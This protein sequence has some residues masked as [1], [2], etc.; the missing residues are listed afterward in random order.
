MSI[1]ND[2][3]FCIDECG[4]DDNQTEELLAVCEELGGISCEYFSEEF[5][6]IIDNEDLA[7]YHDDSY[8][9]IA[10]FN[11]LHWKSKGENA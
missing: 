9:N 11:A 10:H 6:F 3:Q 1:E 8:L 5:V 4:L 2:L 7:K